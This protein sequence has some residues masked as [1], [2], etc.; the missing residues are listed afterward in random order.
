MVTTN[1]YNP[2]IITPNHEKRRSFNLVPEREFLEQIT[3]FTGPLDQFQK[4]DNKTLYFTLT[5]DYGRNMESG[6]PH[7]AGVE[8]HMFESLCLLMTVFDLSMEIGVT[9]V[10]SNNSVYYFDTSVT[11]NTDYREIEATIKSDKKLTHP[12][13]MQ[14]DNFFNSLTNYYLYVIGSINQRDIT[15]IT[16]KSIQ[17][18]AHKL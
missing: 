8:S 7:G 1:D 6:V 13:R 3:P 15:E 11:Y 5:T 18:F 2:Y 16:G 14:D 4:A 9:F 12:W 17:I 10:L